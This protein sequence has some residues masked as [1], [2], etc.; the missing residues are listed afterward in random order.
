MARQPLSL[1]K[2][3]ALITLAGAGVLF[4]ADSAADRALAMAGQIPDAAATERPELARQALAEAERAV[5]ESPNS[6]QSHL[7]LAIV[8]GRVSEIQPPNKRLEAA[9]RIREQL[10]IA[11]RLDPKEP[12]AWHVLGRWHLELAILPPVVRSLAETFFG[13]LP[14]ASAEEAETAFRNSMQHG[15]VRIAN[16]SELGRTLALLGKTREAHAEFEKALSLPAK[17]REDEDAR[18]R[19][20]LALEQLGGR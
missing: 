15:P 3:V 10:D 4:A 2:A 17:N 11:L 6:A 9:R 14:E 8:L 7:A 1:Q 5:A 20:R 18:Q 13:K 12:L 19:A 16:H